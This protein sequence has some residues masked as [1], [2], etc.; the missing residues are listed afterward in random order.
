VSGVHLLLEAIVLLVCIV[1]LVGYALFLRM[2]LEQGDRVLT[3]A[4]PV[5]TVVFLF[6]VVWVSV[7]L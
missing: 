5:S 1:G 7:A 3:L 2:G 4:A 6:A